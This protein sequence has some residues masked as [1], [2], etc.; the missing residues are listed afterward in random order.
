MTSDVA[1]SIGAREE[2]AF[3]APLTGGARFGGWERL[4]AGAGLALALIIGI[5]LRFWFVASADFP[6]NDGGLF[7]LMTGELQHAQGKLFLP[8]WVFSILFQNPRNPVTPAAVSLAM[9]VSIGST[10]LIA[11]RLLELSR[12]VL[13]RP[14]GG[15]A[16]ENDVAV[17]DWRTRARGFAPFTT[18]T[19]MGVALISYTALGARSFLKWSELEV[20]SR[21]ERNAM[22]WSRPTPRTRAG[23][24]C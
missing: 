15:V 10:R 24:S 8:A 6:L 11:P 4:A 21:A 18:I 1:A 7:Y 2:S 23:F 16:F 17:A 3:S 22:Q 19:V 9:L 13:P 20:L 12:A 14:N 5:Y